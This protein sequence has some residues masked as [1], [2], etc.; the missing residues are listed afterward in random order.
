MRFENGATAVFEDSRK[1]IYG[2]DQRLEI[3]GTRGMLQIKNPY[4][5]NVCHANESGT[6]SDVNLDFFMDRYETSYLLEMKSFIDAVKNKK[7]M[8][9]D[10]DEGIEAMV[11][12]E[13]AYKSLHENRP[14]NIE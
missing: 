4:K 9:V 6:N 11:I 14:I 3:F 5:S 8:P 2:Y 10:G 1:S 7:Q 13:A 12:A